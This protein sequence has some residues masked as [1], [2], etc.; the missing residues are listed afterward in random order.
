MGI[1]QNF[2]TESHNVQGQAYTTPVPYE[3]TRGNVNA[4]DLQGGRLYALPHSRLVTNQPPLARAQELRSSRTDDPDPTSLGLSVLAPESSNFGLTA[5][6]ATDHHTRRE[7]STNEQTKG[8]SA[9]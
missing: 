1:T 3:R 5:R 6:S 4:P 9:K 8:R 2:S 7:E